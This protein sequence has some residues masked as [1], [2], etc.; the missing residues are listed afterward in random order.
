MM[1]PRSPASAARAVD[2]LVR[3]GKR[4]RETAPPMI[5]ASR[6]RAGVTATAC[7]RCGRAPRSAP[8]LRPRSGVASGPGIAVRLLGRPG[9]P[10]ELA[11]D[12]EPP[13]VC[14]ALG[15]L[16]AHR[17]TRAR[18]HHRHSVGDGDRPRDGAAAGRR[19][20]RSRRR[21]RVG[22]RA[23]HRRRRARRRA[24]AARATAA[25][26]IGVVGS[27]LDVLYPRCERGGCG[28]M[29]PPRA[30]CSPRRRRARRRRRGGSPPAIASSPR[31]PISSWS[32]SPRAAGG[33]MLTVREADRA[34]TPGDGGARARCEPGVRGHEPAHLRRL[35]PGPRRARRARRARAHHSAARTRAARVVVAPAV[36]MARCSRCSTPATALDVE[37]IVR[38]LRPTRLPTRWLSRSI[39]SKP[40]AGSSRNGAW[41]QPDMTG[42]PRRVAGTVRSCRRRARGTSRRSSGR[43]PPSRPRPARPTAATSRRSS[44]GP[45]ALALDGPERVERTTLRRYLAYLADPPLRARA[46]SPGTRR[47]LRRYFGWLARTGRIDGRPRGRSPRAEGRGPAAPRAA[48]RRAPGA[49][50][51]AAR[52]GRRRRR[53]DPPPRRRR[54]RA[55]LRQRPPGRRAVRPGAEPTSTA[56]IGTVTVWGKGSKQ[57]KV[58]LSEPAVEAVAGWLQRTAASTWSRDVDARPTRCS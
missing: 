39:A 47:R 43:S 33:S 22:P 34:R 31:S 35:L 8:T 14:F 54:A 44:S 45:S 56:R 24:P 42:S 41:W 13:A 3:R 40:R 27:G 28:P 15:D 4:W 52:H 6:P 18:R 16:A 36:S 20:R 50:R 21:G 19:A 25:A 55:A 58:P 10:A 38:V 1:G 37:T 12:P 53:G 49:A 17:R 9:Y 30:S 5:R 48:R 26:P 11:A 57:R 2:A 7:G 51:R 32:S 29:S 23:R 46:R